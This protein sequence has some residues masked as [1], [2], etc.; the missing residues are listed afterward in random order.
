MHNIYVSVV[1]YFPRHDYLE[2]HSKLIYQ[3]SRKLY[4]FL[5]RLCFINLYACPHFEF[6]CN[7]KYVY[8]KP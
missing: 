4:I 1:R 7:C 6:I 5:Q 8:D 2:L 3:V